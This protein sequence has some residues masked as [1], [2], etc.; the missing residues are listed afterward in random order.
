MPPLIAPPTDLT[1]RDDLILRAAEATH[2]LASTLLAAHEEYWSL[3]TERL[4]AVLNDDVAATLE[5]FALNTSI[6]QAI[7]AS[8][9]S[10]NLPQF[11]KRAPT[12][13]GRADIVFNGTEFVL[14]AE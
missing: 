9:D 3:P 10:I 7:N 2:H 13:T 8:L 1:F 6:A 12:T 14:A 4:L 5:T 11:P